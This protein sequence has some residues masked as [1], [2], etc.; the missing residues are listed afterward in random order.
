MK[1]SLRDIF[2]HAVEPTQDAETADEH[3]AKRLKV[4]TPSGYIFEFENDVQINE[5]EIFMPIPEWHIKD[6]NT[7][8][9]N[10][11]RVKNCD[12]VITKPNPQ[13]DGYSRVK[14]KGS[15]YRLTHLMLYAFNVPQP[16]AEHKE[17]NHKDLDPTN[18]CLENLE[19]VTCKENLQHS[20]RTNKNRKSSAPKQSKPVECCINGKWHTYPSASEAARQ[21]NLPQGRISEACHKKRFL[22]GYQFRW[23]KPR[24]EI[25]KKMKKAII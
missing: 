13:T 3:P 4:H 9:S 25:S 24:R 15:K 22:P 2:G 17:V 18:N 1:R 14:V 6:N 11:G 23:G 12:G 10:Q 7:F 19:W 21:L 8:V 16:S 20:H 5:G